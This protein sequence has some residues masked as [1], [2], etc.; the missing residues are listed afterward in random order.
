ME[1]SSVG[2]WV[3]TRAS[4]MKKNIYGN[5]EDLVCAHLFIGRKQLIKHC[6]LFWICKPKK[7]EVIFP[8]QYNTLPSFFFFPP[9][10]KRL[11]TWR[12]WLHAGWLRRA[13]KAP[14]CL[15]GR[16][17]TISSWDLKVCSCFCFIV[18]SGHL[19][20]FAAVFAHIWSGNMR[21]I[22]MLTHASAAPCPWSDCP[23]LPTIYS[24]PA[25]PD[26]QTRLT[27][28]TGT[29]TFNSALPPKSFSHRSYFQA[30]F[31]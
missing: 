25:A 29:K 12:W 24:I 10:G 20:A 17:F 26:I 23:R 5:I 7:G 11:S 13:A 16:T 22:L 4:G 2:G 30:F 19:G 18:P 28:L 14:A 31:L 1:F 15:R 3:A 21:F 6:H 9:G 27:Y 8:S